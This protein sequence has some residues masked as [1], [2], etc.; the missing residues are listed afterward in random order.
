MQIDPWNVIDCRGM[1]FKSWGRVGSNR[2][3]HAEWQDKV[4][5]SQGLSETFPLTLQWVALKLYVANKY[6]CHLFYSTF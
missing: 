4:V 2:V 5:V 3:G 1:V 6:L